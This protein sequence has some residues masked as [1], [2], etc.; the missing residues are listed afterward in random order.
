MFIGLIGAGNISDTHARAAAAIPNVKIAAVY[1]RDGSKAGRLAAR[2]GAT[3]YDDFERFLD[4]RPMDLVA[5]GTPS[6]LHAEHG[7]KAA[8]RG[9]HVLV[10]KPMDVTTARADALIAAA[11]DNHVKLGVFFQDRFSE[12]A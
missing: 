6:G 2:H 4:H 8:R 1:A 7:I 9:L 12:G 11:T 5:I 10:E 3:A